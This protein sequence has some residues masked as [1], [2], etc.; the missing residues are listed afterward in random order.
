MLIT[1]PS[2]YLVSSQCNALLL[3][4]RILGCSELV[5]SSKNLRK[6]IICVLSYVSFLLPRLFWTIYLSHSLAALKRKALKKKRKRKERKK[7]K[8]KLWNQHTNNSSCVYQISALY[9]INILALDQEVLK[10]SVSIRI[11]TFDLRPFFDLISMCCFDFV[12]ISVYHSCS[13]FFAV[14]NPTSDDNC[15]GFHHLVG[16]TPGEFYQMHNP[17]LC[18]IYLSFNYIME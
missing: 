5:L 6:S 13:N 9:L 3:P 12:W 4:L 10:Y 2:Y 16:F 7:K 8:K 15:A 1:S 17:S 11:T 18:I 14:L